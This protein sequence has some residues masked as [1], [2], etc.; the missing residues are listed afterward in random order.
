MSISYEEERERTI[1]AMG[2]KRSYIPYEGYRIRQ[3]IGE[4][5]SGGS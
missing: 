3:S 5:G 2:N 1:K 4:G